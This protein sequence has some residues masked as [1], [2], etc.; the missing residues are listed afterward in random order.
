MCVHTHTLTFTSQACI[1]PP[2]THLFVV[3]C[4][5]MLTTWDC[6]WDLFS[7]KIIRKF[8]KTWGMK[9]A[10][11]CECQ[12]MLCMEMQ[13][14]VLPMNKGTTA[15]TIKNTEPIFLHWNGLRS[16]YLKW[17]AMSQKASRKGCVSFNENLKIQ[18]NLS[19]LIIAVSHIG[20]MWLLNFWFGADAQR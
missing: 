3:S 16:C 5:F 6:G 17:S 9:Q 12:T 14:K 7:S 13:T 18:A 11:D 4:V 20:Y 10:E 1:T 2:H 19:L 15:S 8:S